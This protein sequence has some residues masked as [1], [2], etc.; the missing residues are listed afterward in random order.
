MCKI[1]VMPVVRPDTAQLAWSLAK[2]MGE[3]MS[4]GNS[5]GL[6]Y[7]AVDGEGNL[8][9]ER[10]LRNHE[11]FK[12]RVEFTTLDRVNIDDYKGFLHKEER[13]DRFGAS[14]SEENTRA[15]IL[16]TRF[17]TSGKQFYNTHPFYDEDTA[18][19]HNGVISN[20]N[21]KELKISTCDSEKILREYLHF[22]VSNR[23]KR[24]Q[25][26]AA[27]LE[28]YYACA[29]LSKQKDGT[30]ILDVFK[31]S[32]A[33]L[34]GAW[35]RE[36]ASIVITTHLGDLVEA[37]KQLNLHVDSMYEV[38]SGVLL[39]FNTL[40]GKPVGG[41]KFTPNTVR[42]YRSYTGGFDM[43]YDSDWRVSG[44]SRTAGGDTH[45]GKYG[46]R[47]V[48]PG[49]SQAGDR[50]EGRGSGDAV[51]SVLRMTS[52]D[53]AARDGWEYNSHAKTWKRVAKP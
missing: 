51:S 50:D 32:A 40:T 52:S 34:G 23:P 53:Q 13:Y 31:E 29:V 20:V 28:G 27:A 9:G 41:T 35:V 21:Q 39:R 22:D 4:K 8:F 37:A 7:A 16:H 36:L 26:V 14:I 43:D 10:W 42:S 44:Y 3:I 11:A 25:K 46:G 45:V 33:S 1:L 12:D 6:G 30:P 2:K 48:S 38:K 17:A 47:W 18:L 5:D 19:I 15:I 24:I 49:D